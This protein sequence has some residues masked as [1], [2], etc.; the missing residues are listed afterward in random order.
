MHKDVHNLYGLLDSYY[1]YQALKED[2]NKPL[3]FILTRSTFPGSGKY[4]FH[5][6]GDNAASYDFLQISLPAIILFNI[7]GI[8]MTGFYFFIYLKN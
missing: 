4:A 3:P 6:T 7:F 5:W 2:L 1:T 8:P